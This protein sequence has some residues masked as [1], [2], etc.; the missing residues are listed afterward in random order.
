M[1]ILHSLNLVEKHIRWNMR[2]V[3]QKDKR[4]KDNYG[5]APVAEW[6]HRLCTVKTRTHNTQHPV[7]CVYLSAYI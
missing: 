7:F 3:M 2:H 6:S 5:C 4:K 1:L